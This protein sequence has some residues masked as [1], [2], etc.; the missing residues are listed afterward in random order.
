MHF[1]VD[2]YLGK[3]T[4]QEILSF[5]ARN[6]KIDAMLNNEFV[7][8]IDIVMKETVGVKGKKMNLH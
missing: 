7:E 3:Q 4:V 2:H 6:L 8:R 1:R 5:R